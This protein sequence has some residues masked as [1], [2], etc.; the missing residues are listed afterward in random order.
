MSTYKIYFKQTQ[1]KLFYTCFFFCFY[2]NFEWRVSH[3]FLF[4][5]REHSSSVLK[6]IGRRQPTRS[7][8]V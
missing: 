4:K 8:M 7:T 6:E 5:H 1:V 2:K 3:Y